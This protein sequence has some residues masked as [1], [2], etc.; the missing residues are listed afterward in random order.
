MSFHHIVVISFLTSLSVLGVAYPMKGHPEDV[1]AKRGG[2]LKEESV[3]SS[4]FFSFPMSICID[5]CQRTHA[6]LST[7]CRYSFFV[8]N[9]GGMMKVLS[10]HTLM[11]GTLLDGCDIFQVMICKG[12]EL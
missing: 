9:Y 8:A 2:S 7:I 1:F 3:C 11:V 10:L 5:V 12:I 6:K 4:F